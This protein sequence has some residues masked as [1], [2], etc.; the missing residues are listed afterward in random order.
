LRSTD[1][2]GPLKELPAEALEGGQASAEFEFALQE[3]D[4]SETL[5]AYGTLPEERIFARDMAVEPK[6]RELLL[7]GVDVIVVESYTALAPRAVASSEGISEVVQAEFVHL[8]QRAKEEGRAVVLQLGGSNPHLL[9]RKVYLR[10][11]FTQ[12]GLKCGYL[13]WRTCGQTSWGREQSWKN[14]V[15]LGLQLP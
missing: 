10:P 6:V 7:S 3:L 9:A 15:C 1:S 8:L 5:G 2:G 14:R 13:R 11:P 4:V 12:F